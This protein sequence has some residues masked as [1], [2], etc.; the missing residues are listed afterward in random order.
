MMYKAALLPGGYSPRRF[1]STAAR[2]QAVR[3]ASAVALTLLSLLGGAGV[4]HLFTTTLPAA[5]SPSMSS[6]SLLPPSAASV[7]TAA[8]AQKVLS[9][10]VR[11]DEAERLLGMSHPSATQQPR[12][13]TDDAAPGNSPKR[14][15]YPLLGPVRK[16]VSEGAPP[17]AFFGHGEL[18]THPGVS[19]VVSDTYRFIYIIVHKAG[20]QTTRAY[21]MNSL[22]GSRSAA[23]AP[24]SNCTA[25]L[26]NFRDTG[27]RYTLCKH[28][29]RAK[30]ADYYVFSH[31][32]NVWARAVSTYSF[33]RMGRAAG[34][35]WAAWCADPDTH[36]DCFRSGGEA[37]AEVVQRGGPPPIKR[38]TNEHWGPQLPRLCTPSGECWVDYVGR[39][40]EIG[41][42][43]N[44]VIDA[45]NARRD[46]GLAP[47]PPFVNRVI[48]ARRGAAPPAAWYLPRSA[49]SAT[50]AAAADAAGVTPEPSCRAAIE[51]YYA[52][53]VA[54]FGSTFDDMT[55]WGAV[56]G[57]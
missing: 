29:P 55:A 52:A 41:V 50:D 49:L 9:D 48:N 13:A 53:D 4:Y 31:T 30:F 6:S 36:R 26:L 51:R 43:L 40:E 47:L 57:G 3:C 33:C 23:D 12:D 27:A 10:A 15:T 18:G 37:A 56:K 24:N 54:A 11:V 32:R 42:H 25:P 7:A 44:A 14:P 17:P 1:A 16:M 28:V 38:G 22:C 2:R 21:L 46:A 8:A 34:I 5:S 19:C 20:S 45:I 39:S 35:S